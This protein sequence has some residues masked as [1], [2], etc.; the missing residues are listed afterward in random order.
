MIAS[1]LLALVLSNASPDCGSLDTQSAM[2]ECAS[3]AATRAD[4]RLNRS[5]AAARSALEGRHLSAGTLTSAQLAWI[6][7]RDKTCAFER[8]L[9]T[10]GSLASYITSSCVARLSQQRAERLE[11]YAQAVSGHALRERRAVEVSVD[12]ALNAAYSALRRATP[13]STMWQLENA[14][15]AWITYR[16]RACAI[17]GGNCVTELESERTAELKTAYPGG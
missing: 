17:E 11:G 13:K 12:R 1:M 9:Y 5:Y 8:A 10:N 4:A 6:D 16:D 14:E 2:N 3:D 7:M 15:V